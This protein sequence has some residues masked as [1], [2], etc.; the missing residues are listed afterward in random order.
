MKDKSLVPAVITTLI[1][2][3]IFM[4]ICIIEQAK[5]ARHSQDVIAAFKSEIDAM[6]TENRV[7]ATSM[8]ITKTKLAELRVDFD[9]L[10]MYV[11]PPMKENLSDLNKKVG[12]KKKYERL[13]L[14][15]R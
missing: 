4:L 3:I 9:T 10:R 14:N 13:D 1:L 12:F 2:L 11:I 15:D 5:E 7:I 6:K 8:A